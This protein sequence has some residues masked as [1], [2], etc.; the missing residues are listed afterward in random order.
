MN[1]GL[2]KIDRLIDNHDEFCRMSII[3]KVIIADK[4]LTTSTELIVD[5]KGSSVIFYQ[6]KKQTKL[7]IIYEF[8]E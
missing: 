1:F 6:F 7:I 8:M 4:D 5:M 3:T 2:E